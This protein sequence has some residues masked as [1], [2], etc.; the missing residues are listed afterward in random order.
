MKTLEQI[1]RIVELHKLIQKECTGTSSTLAK[2]L[3][4]SQRMVQEYLAELRLL[5]ADLRYNS[6]R[7]TYYYMNNFTIKFIFEIGVRTNSEIK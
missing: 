7:C 3:G 4:I 2:H 6:N 1:K 5:G